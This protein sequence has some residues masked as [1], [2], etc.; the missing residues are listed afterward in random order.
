MSTFQEITSKRAGSSKAISPLRKRFSV[1]VTSASKGLRMQD[2]VNFL[3]THD[4][5]QSRP[6][7]NGVEK[8]VLR[9][10]LYPGDG[11]LI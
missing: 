11:G 3:R 4:C 9:N 5:D 10:K 6:E 2:H 1:V 8:G 7:K